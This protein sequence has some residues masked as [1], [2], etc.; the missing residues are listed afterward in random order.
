[1]AIDGGGSVCRALHLG[2]FSRGK[3]I[4]DQPSLVS[5]EQRA[6]FTQLRQ[7]FESLALQSKGLHHTLLQSQRSPLISK[8]ADNDIPPVVSEN[9]QPTDP[10]FIFHYDTLPG[11]PPRPVA[12]NDEERIAAPPAK[13]NDEYIR[14]GRGRALAK[15]IPQVVRMGFLTG[16]DS[17]IAQFNSVSEAVG[18]ALLGISDEA[19]LKF[20]ESIRGV[21]RENRSVHCRYVFGNVP[22][23]TLPS[24][25]WA[26]QGWQAGV[27]VFDEGIVI[28]NSECGTGSGSRS[29]A[30]HLLLHQMGWI[31]PIG[32]LL[33][34][35]R[36]HWQDNHC[37]LFGPIVDDPGFPE[38]AK[39]PLHRFYSVLG[40]TS[41]SPPDACLASAWAID[42]LLQMLS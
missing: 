9:V 22:T 6:I 12:L 28:D 39:V 42:R 8:V 38:L 31:A 21:F 33:R 23:E 1:V 11:D 2:T 37:V 26:G 40:G 41:G 4:R 32:S 15:W 25:P 35:T 34:A 24:L 17:V 5:D 10:R 7:T 19:I 13:E 18:Q 14:D 36:W 29:G 3:S 27:T 16:D 20:P 30:W